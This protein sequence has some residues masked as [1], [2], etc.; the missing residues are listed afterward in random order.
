MNKQIFLGATM[1]SLLAMVACNPTTQPTTQTGN[2]D[3][4]V[5]APCEKQDTA[6]QTATNNV[7]AHLNVMWE[8]Q[9]KLTSYETFVADTLQPQA[10]AVFM[11]DHAVRDFKVLALTFVDVDA[12]G[13]MNFTTKTQYTLDQLTP[14]KPLLVKATL[15]G[16]IPNLGV[17]YVDH[18]GKT[19]QFAVQESGEDGSALLL[20][21]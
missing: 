6:K 20:E 4:A 1:C 8:E 14:E 21:F 2:P 5:V 18:T 9:A 10:K 7:E 3:T 15:F 19:R 12:N 11:V 16:T 17:S 13:K